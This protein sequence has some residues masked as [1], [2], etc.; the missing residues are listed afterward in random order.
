MAESDSRLLAKEAQKKGYDVYSEIEIGDNSDVLKK[1]DEIKK[2]EGFTLEGA[3]TS[4]L[5][6]EEKLAEVRKKLGLL[7]KKQQPKESI[8]MQ[9]SLED[10]AKPMNEYL[11]QTFKKKRRKKKKSS[12]T[13]AIEI[14]NINNNI[15]SS[16][17]TMTD[18][19]SS[20]DHGSRAISE[21]KDKIIQNLEIQK[22]QTKAKAY[23]KAIHK[24][25]INSLALLDDDN[26]EEDNELYESLKKKRNIG[27]NNTFALNPSNIA[28]QIKNRRQR[29]DASTK[30]EDNIN[31]GVIFSSTSEFVRNIDT[32][33]QKEKRKDIISPSIKEEKQENIVNNE[34][35]I[36][37][38]KDDSMDIDGDEITQKEDPITIEDEPLVSEG[39]GATLK[40]IQKTGDVDLLKTDGLIAG[41]RTDAILSEDPD[42][43]APD[44]NLNHYDKY[45]RVL[46][47]K[48]RFREMSHQ[49]HGRGPSLNKKEK[50]LRK[51]H[52]ELRIPEN[53]SDTTSIGRN[54][55]TKTKK[56]KNIVYNAKAT[57]LAGP[58]GQLFKP[59]PEELNAYKDIS[60]SKSS[61]AATKRT[62]TGKIEFALSAGQKRKNIDG[63][64]NDSNPSPKKRAKR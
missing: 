38:L 60:Q 56:R 19:D 64:S 12:R 25:K 49:F 9:Y 1:Y 30:K 18:I 61:T 32:T 33:S 15:T 40:Y 57:E 44:I 2:K 54:N 35:Q 23:E 48:E 21:K 52:Q 53:T 42:D 7:S 10:T 3:T 31:S 29:I 43:P 34:K 47:I 17:I 39:I 14:S 41:R 27:R 4:T 36:E 51:L 8:K 45:G 24:A 62:N 55:E 46:T 58:T 5:S 6:K 16:D 50:Q 59:K 37:N 11:P 13:H 28:S 22:K 20:E 63:Y 26:I